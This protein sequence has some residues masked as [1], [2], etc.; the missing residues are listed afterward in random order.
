MRRTAFCFATMLV[1]AA[2]ARAAVLPG[3]QREASLRFVQ[4]L[5]NPD[6]G[7]RAAPASGPSSVGAT[8]SCLR[9][10]QH[11][12]GTIPK[13]EET[14]R[15]VL[16]CYNAGSGGFAD[17]PGGAV[18]VRSTAM[19]LMSLAELE[20][21]VTERPEVRGAA[22][23]LSKNAQSLPD[24]YIAAA[25]LDAAKLPIPD[26]APW[27]AAWEATRNP[28][29]TYGKSPTDTARALITELRLGTRPRE[30]ETAIRSL[31]AAQKPDGGFAAMGDASD[32]ATVYSV[33]R[34][35]R[36]VCEKP[37]L[38]HLRGFIARCRNSDGG[39]GPSPGQSSA[40]SPTYFAAIV[41]DWAEELERKA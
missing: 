32:L 9:A 8:T 18:D 34:A 26:A 14:R 21:P 7:Y 35:F 6:G 23:Y 22:V 13:R 41:L 10:I 28:D 37:D 19:G 5:Q 27:T 25:A 36:M 39:Y 12:G 24:I 40:A 4:S 2:A 20:L 1:L 11:L 17:S 33:M 16:T 29:G 30:T 3:P 38:E 31:K 15:F